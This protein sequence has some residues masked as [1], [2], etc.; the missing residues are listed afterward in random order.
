[1]C[2]CTH[3]SAQGLWRGV[4][5]FWDHVVLAVIFVGGR[6]KVGLKNVKVEVGFS[7]GAFSIG[8]LII[9]IGLRGPLYYKH[10]EEHP[11]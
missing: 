6:V 9:R 1:M 4:L 8:V 7:F 11:K 3:N 10:M 5:G 2:I